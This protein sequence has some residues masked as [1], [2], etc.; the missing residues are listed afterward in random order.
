MSVEHFESS[1]SAPASPASGPATTCRRLP[2]RLR[3]PGRARR[4]GRDLGPVPLP[5]S[6]IRLR[7]VHAR[8]LLPALEG[9]QGHRRRAGHPEVSPGDRPRVRHRPPHPLPAA[10][11]IRVVVVRAGGAG[12]SR[13]RWAS[14]GSR[15]A[16]PAI[17]CS[18]A[19]A[20]TTTRRATCRP[21]PAARTS[22]DRSS[23]RSTGRQTSTT[24]ASAVVVIGSGAT[25]VTLVP[26]LAETA[27]HVTMLQRSPSY[28]LS[29]PAED[30]LARVIRRL[31][32]GAGRSPAH[33]L[34]K[35]PA[36]PSYFYQLCRR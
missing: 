30:R 26:A 4:P 35:H 29:I 25:A 3:D 31:S 27:A 12:P 23:T 28:I 17:S 34:E 9:G 19:A 33:P 20:T 1:S 18:C 16:T 10:G 32:A 36:R 13:R 8:L 2:A 5:R 7:H 14:T 15:S 11:A 6:P 22:G 24:A 21:S